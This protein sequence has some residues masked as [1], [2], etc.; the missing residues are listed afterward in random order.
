MIQ[1]DDFSLDLTNYSLTQ[2]DKTLS[3]EP[4]VF[5]LLVYL[6]QNRD[7]VVGRD[8]LMDTLWKG[9]V[10]SDSTLS[11]CVKEARK[12]LGDDADTQTYIKTLHRRG[13]RFVRQLNEFL[14]TERTENEPPKTTENNP[15]RPSA[16]DK[17]SIALLPFHCRSNNEE[18]FWLSEV[19]GEDLCITLANVPGFWV[20]SYSSMESYRDQKVDARIIGGDLGVNYLVEG[21]LMNIGGRYRISLQLIK[22]EDNSL[23]WADRHEFLEDELIKIQNQIAARI[24]A[25]F[26]PAINRAELVQLV[27]RRRANLSAW[28]LYRQSHAILAQKGWT[29]ECFQESADL[30][31]EATR[32]DPE[33][34]PAHAY[35]S[36]VLAL[37][38]VF[39]LLSD[40]GAEEEA[41]SS[42]EK[43]ISLDP[44]DSSVLGFAGCALVDL[45]KVER[46]ITLLR[47]AVEIN[48]SNAQAL[49]ALGASLLKIGNFDGLD[50]IRNGIQIS[51]RDHRLA[52]W[53][54]LL[55]GGLLACGKLEEA[56]KIARNACDYDD[57]VYAP[58]ML[59]AV[60]H[61]K[62]G[63][64]SEAKEAIEDAKRIHPKLSSEI[65]PGISCMRV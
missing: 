38:N 30:L 46:G 52:A 50:L 7:R 42:A 57:K 31:R 10:V 8:E 2:G 29:E 65:L 56:Q 12:A 34:A 49:A 25:S 9:K 16:N 35:L 64:L 3:I 48:P 6:I 39:G 41:Q 15:F 59:L 32:R 14:L 37:G 33:L 43:A 51:P 62:K 27:K 19:L 20:I 55:S 18:D 1:F 61:W 63:E 26:E 36:L 53:G 4:Q 23:L 47:K 17:T 60:T 5:D 24:V 11:S 13:Y 21:T 28:Q 54:T 58:R 44:Q 22:T 40:E 45:G